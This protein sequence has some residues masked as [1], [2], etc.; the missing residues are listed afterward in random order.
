MSDSKEYA[1]IQRKVKMKKGFYVHLGMYGVIIFFLF[2]M[3]VLTQDPGPSDWW[4]VFPAASWGVAIAIHAL[5]V[6]IFSSDGILGEDWEQ[7]QI[8]EALAK[9]GLYLENKQLPTS[10]KLDID[11]H[12]DLKEMKKETRYDEQDLV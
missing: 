8:E 12:L 4:F 5:A 11:Q 7:K 6:F 9:K 2:I 1:K 10:E 3:N